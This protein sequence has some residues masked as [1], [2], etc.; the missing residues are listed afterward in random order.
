VGDP[1]P[2]HPT[3]YQVSLCSPASQLW[4]WLMD[5]GKSGR[6][7]TAGPQAT[8]PFLSARLGDGDRDGDGG[9]E[10]PEP[11]AARGAVQHPGGLRAPGPVSSTA[12]RQARHVASAARPPGASVVVAREARRTDGRT[13]GRRR[14]AGRG[15]GVGARGPVRRGTWARPG[16]PRAGRPRRG[17]RGWGPAAGG[18]SSLVTTAEPPRGP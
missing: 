3:F 1:F 10:V 5:S 8:A 9:G 12:A 16:S 13:D 4:L 2:C 7:P 15:V 11:R 17:S 6:A 18:G 14:G